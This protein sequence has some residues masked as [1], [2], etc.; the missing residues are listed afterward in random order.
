MSSSCLAGRVSPG[1][2]RTSMIAFL[3]RA[4]KLQAARSAAFLIP[5]GLGAQE[6]AFLLIGGAL[7]PAQRRYRRPRGVGATSGLNLRVWRPPFARNVPV[8]TQAPHAV[9]LNVL[10]LA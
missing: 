4:A 1:R 3:I 7:V 10:L 5:G 2:P 8:P 9:G 6:G